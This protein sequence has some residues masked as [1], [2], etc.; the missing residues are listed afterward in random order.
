MD[1]ENATPFPTRVTRECLNDVHGMLI[2]TTKVTYTRV[3]G[4]L[5]LDR[6]Q[7]PLPLDPCDEAPL[8]ELNVMREPGITDLTVV[9]DVVAPGE[10]PCSAVDVKLS[11]NDEVRVLRAF[12]PR[13]WQRGA[14]DFHPSDP[15]PF[16][17]LPM[18]WKH[19][20]GGRHI[21]PAGFAPHSR[22][23]MPRGELAFSANPGGAGFYFEPEQ[24]E[25]Q[26][27]PALEDPENLIRTWRDQ[28][29]PACFAPMPMA[30]SLRTE[31]VDIHP[32]TAAM[33][34]RHEGEMIFARFRQN[35]PPWLQQR[36]LRPGARVRLE[37]MTPDEPMSFTLP[38]PPVR[39][40]VSTG[41]RSRE[42]ETGYLAIQLRP[43][44]DKVTVLLGG[45]VFYS[46]IKHETRHAHLTMTPAGLA[47]AAL[48]RGG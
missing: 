42:Q 10:R 12:G 31:H 14:E 21:I 26:A 29:R 8:G 41:N 27:L 22:L 5:V 40:L 11:W 36:G 2:T 7:L 23:P 45:N 47:Q 20:Y 30:S 48:T 24:V 39:W 43:G 6:E 32:E 3:N 34:S 25:G 16:V 17:R 28:P 44:E 19:A 4:S 15:E 18:E 35:A 33:K 9:G 13:V 1:I 38:E 37:G 46:L